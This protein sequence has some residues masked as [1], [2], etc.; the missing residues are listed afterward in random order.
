MARY[1]KRPV[2]IEAE[3]FLDIDNPPTGV[4]VIASPASSAARGY[5]ARVMTN[6]GWAEVLLHDWV[7]R[8]LETG[9]RYPCRPDRFA[10]IYE[11]VELGDEA[12]G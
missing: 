8:D 11:P 3:Q 9:E 12:G 2:V 1:R 5:T 4:E 7:L 6:H 10:A